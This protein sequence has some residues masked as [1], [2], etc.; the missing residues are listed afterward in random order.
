M[1]LKTTDRY[2]I[3]QFLKPLVVVLLTFMGLFLFVDTAEKVRPIMRYLKASD[4]NWVEVVQYLLG[5]LFGYL[6]ILIPLVL[7]LSISICF[8]LL[9]QTG[10]MRAFASFTLPYKRVFLGP[11]M[12]CGIVGGLSFL[13]TFQV[14]PDVKRNTDLLY[15]KIRN[16]SGIFK[17]IVVQE[18]LSLSNLSS[19]Y[20]KDSRPADIKKSY[21]EKGRPAV[22]QII[23]V[24]N[25]SSLTGEIEDLYILRFDENNRIVRRI[26]MKNSNF[27]DG[28]IVGENGKDDLYDDGHFI[29][30]Q[31]IETP[32]YFATNF[33]LY[34]ILN[35][36]F[37]SEDVTQVSIPILFEKRTSQVAKKEIVDRAMY[38]FLVLLFSLLALAISSLFNFTKLYLSFGLLLGI[39]GFY[40]ILL[41]GAMAILPIHLHWASSIFVMMIG[42]FIMIKTYKF[43]Q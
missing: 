22:L 43:V 3:A 40:V 2:V 30:S 38:P 39:I 31:V 14:L 18:N 20:L 29:K 27:V 13:L 12:I 26:Q 25:L 5:N 42:Y 9:N 34:S 1:F 7:S 11:F 41:L 6:M 10:Q 19:E 23:E 17:D 8:I 35:E 4:N 33:T 21:S 37:L 28:F 32:T 36:Y 15:K 16:V 24:R